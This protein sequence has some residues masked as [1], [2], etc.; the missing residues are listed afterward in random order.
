LANID[1]RLHHINNCEA[2]NCPNCNHTFKQGVEQSEKEKLEANQTKGLEI[3]RQTATKVAELRSFLEEAT[4]YLRSLD[5]ISGWRQ[6][7]A[8]LKGFWE[9]IA[10]AGG[11]AQGS[12]LKDV[13]EQY[14]RDARLVAQILELREKLA[15][16]KESLDTLEK[17]SGDGAT[18]RERYYFLKSRIEETNADIN[19][20]NKD[21]SVMEKY[22]RDLVGYDATTQQLIERHAEMQKHIERLVEAIRQDEIRGVIKAHQTNLSIAETAL[23]ESEV[24]Q[25]IIKDI[26]KEI[27]LMSLRQKAWKAIENELCPK[28]GMISESIGVFIN[29]LIDRM[30]AVIAR[31]WGYNLALKRCDLENGELDYMFPLYAVK[32]ENEVPDVKFGSDSQVSIV[33]LA[34]RL[35]VYK[36][37][38][39]HH[40]PLYLDEM[41]RDF[42][43][44]HRHNLIFA[45]KDLIDDDTYS[46]VFIISHYIDG[47]ASF[48]DAQFIVMDRDHLDASLLPQLE[49]VN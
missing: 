18:I 30:N 47:Q 17:A 12:N 13:C 25:G 28:N 29:T 1:G 41:G 19:K 38:K 32:K 7:H 16:V 42:D 24:Q 2:V 21:L 6:S 44:V 31:I 9:V 45:I 48:P 23:T 8:F 15:P 3:K 34:F 20:A 22:H 35:V 5:H 14:L 37:M 26:T 10:N 40:Y 4:E 43:P 46:Q 11:I 49:G 33:N 36:F 27:E 39:L